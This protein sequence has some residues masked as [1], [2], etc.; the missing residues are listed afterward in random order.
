MGFGDAVKSGF[1][2]Y[3]TFSGRS[4]RSEFWWWQLFTTLISLATQIV[5][6]ILFAL[7]FAG[8]TSVIGSDGR[9]HLEGVS[10]APIIIGGVIAFLVH[11][12]LLIPTLAIMARRLHDMGQPAGWIFLN[13]VFLGIVPFVMAFF[14]S[15]AMANQYGV[16]PKADERTAFPAGYPAQGY[17]APGQP[18]QGYPA[19]GYAVPP[20]APM[21]A[22]Q[23][24]AAPPAPPAP[25]A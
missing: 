5:F 12:A 15:Q 21:A 22:P 2:N 4:R 14:D 24:P 3:A 1:S 23:A 19:Q 16:D 25:P 8:T 20:A 9:T 17:A 6:W 11:I 18:A 7:A 10:P 13:F